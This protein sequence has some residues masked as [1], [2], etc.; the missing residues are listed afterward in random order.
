MCGIAGYIGKFPPSN[1]AIQRAGKSLHHRGPDGEG[2]FNHNFNDSGV[3]LLH[4]RLSIID[5]E[6]R[7]NQPFFFQDTVLIFNGEIFNYLEV[8]KNL[9]KL[10]HVF[11]TNGDTEVL[12]HALCQ[13]GDNALDHLEGMWAFAWYDKKN[14]TILLS[15]D[16]FGE[17]PLY[18]YEKD[19]GLYFSSEIKAIAALAGK[20]P[21]INQSHLIRSL[22][23]G[24]KSLYKTKET[25]FDKVQELSP[26]TLLKID[27][28]SIK[29]T[30]KYWK[31]NFIEDN[32]LTFNESVEITRD[33]LI[34]SVKLRMRSDVPLAFCMS[35]GVDSNSLVSIASKTLN[36]N[37]HG[38]TI[39][40]TDR[41]YNEE[42]LVDKS[43]KELGIEHTKVPLSMKNFLPNI[44]ELV[45]AHD[46]PVS[47]IS[48]Y[49]HWMLLNQ[50]KNKG[51]KIS[52]SGTGADE[53]YSGYYDHHLFYLATIHDQK[54]LYKKT[55]NNWKK[56]VAPI[57]RNKHLQH[58]EIFLNNPNFRDHI[59]SGKDFFHYIKKSFFEPFKEIQYPVNLLRKR[60]LNE[61]FQEIVPVILHE[62]DLNSMYYSIENRSPFLDRNLFENSLKIPTQ[63]L[64]R[65]GKAKSVLRVAMNG[66]VPDSILSNHEKV[67]FNAPIEDLLDFKDSNIKEQILDNSNVFDIIEKKEIEKLIL[68]NKLSNSESKFL[69]SFLNVKIFLEERGF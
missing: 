12:I 43:V 58:P 8:R 29:K 50:M 19:K 27:A 61:L 51:Y 10:G 63:Y 59:Y 48:Y 5:L 66:I 57:V 52:I 45:R 26:G 64:V 65:D 68:K 22:V 17:K 24:Y 56:H 13:W 38:F 31:P 47:T 46:S 2:F 55:I 44:R 4:R 34:N 62:D 36:C 11:Q 40:N 7:S 25:Y 37:V 28:K 14:G 69:F 54:N 67:G 41:R 6:S 21:G 20:W 15:R 1:K 60:M 30:S 16:R 49:V 32:S 39:I 53:L 23:N 42:I 33:S 35:G 3:V 18:I 9:E